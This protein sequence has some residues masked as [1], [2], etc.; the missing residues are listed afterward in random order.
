MLWSKLI[1]S[2]LWRN[3]ETLE[4]QK[5]GRSSAQELLIRTPHS[6]SSLNIFTH[7]SPGN[8]INQFLRCPQYWRCGQKTTPPSWKT[9]FN[10]VATGTDKSIH[11]LWAISM[12]NLLSSFYHMK[13]VEWS[14][15]L[16]MFL[17]FGLILLQ[18][19]SVSLPSPTA[20]ILSVPLKPVFWGYL[21]V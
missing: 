9:V 7:P 6:H 19:I 21:L 14:C 8:L 16:N 12:W 5:P 18:S 11:D 2:S 17:P 20:A 4:G 13:S 15:S 3:Y 1:K 10:I